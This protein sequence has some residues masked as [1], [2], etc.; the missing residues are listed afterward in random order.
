[1]LVHRGVDID[2]ND[3]KRD[4]ALHVASYRQTEATVDLLLDHGANV[5]SFSSEY[6]SSLQAA[7]EGV[8]EYFQR[9]PLEFPMKD[10]DQT[11]HPVSQ[12]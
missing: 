10:N 6:G 7:L 8:A 9:V 1:M 3:G 5:N 4:R 11:G 2:G 12:C